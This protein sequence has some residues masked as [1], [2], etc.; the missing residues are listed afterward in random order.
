MA[1]FFEQEGIFHVHER[2]NIAF[3]EESLAA[4]VPLWFDESIVDVLDWVLHTWA[5]EVVYSIDSHG[6]VRME[7]HQNV[8]V[9]CQKVVVSRVSERFTRTEWMRRLHT[10]ST[11]GRLSR[12]LPLSSLLLPRLRR[13]G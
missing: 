10:V 4:K 3:V 5:S 2:T 11:W 8:S 6:Y 9:V 1:E 7:N 12:S 13:P